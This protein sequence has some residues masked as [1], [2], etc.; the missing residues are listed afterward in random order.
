MRALAGYSVLMAASLGLPLVTRD[1][2]YVDVAT[3]SLMN[4]V[5]TMSLRLEM[6]TGQLNM[7]HISFMGI[8]AYASTLLVMRGG[9]SFW[10]A[11]GVAGAIA[12]AFA[13]P[14]GTLALRVSGP[15]YF[16]ITFAFSEVVRLVFNNFFVPW[17]GGPSGLVEIPKPNPLRLGSLQLQFS[18]KVELYYLM[19]LLFAV[20]VAILVR[21][22]YSRFGLVANAVRQGDLLAETL[23]VRVFRVKLTAFALGSFLAGIAG[24]FFAHS[25]QVLHSSDFGLEPMVLLIV[26]AVVGGTG[27][28]WGPVVG[29]VVLTIVSE[30]MR[31]LHHYEVLVYGTVLI[32]TMLL[33]PEGLYSLPGRVRQLVR[34][35]GGGPTAAMGVDIG[36]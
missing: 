29:T 23:G 9:C 3:T 24:A 12:A 31:E 15:Y 8:G 14:I 2:Y 25:H 20:A 17:F 5:L 7:A 27:S 26:Y 13:L 18:G 19:C 32:L 35:E 11:L 36:S 30:V 33:L 4:L 16:L 6:S 22:D 1:S 28:V 21:L 10:I 34:R